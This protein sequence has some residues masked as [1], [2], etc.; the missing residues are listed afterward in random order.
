MEQFFLVQTCFQ[1]YPLIT[2]SILDFRF[3]FDCQQ[4]TFENT[5]TNRAISS[6]LKFSNISDP[7]I[8]VSN[9]ILQ[10]FLIFSLTIRDIALRCTLLVHHH[11]LLQQTRVHNSVKVFVRIMAFFSTKNLV[12]FFV[13]LF[14][15][16][17]RNC[18]E[19]YNACS[20]LLPSSTDKS[21]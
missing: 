3:N 7:L 20:L 17:Q 9:S 8:T 4:I 12:K 2:V 19:T 6:L 15:N 18:F 11:Y 5:L 10:I 14:Q 13:P 21:A 16:H 1:I